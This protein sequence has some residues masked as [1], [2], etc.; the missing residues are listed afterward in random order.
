MLE[1]VSGYIMLC[2]QGCAEQV[3]DAVVGIRAKAERILSGAQD[4]S[5]PDI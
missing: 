3:T 1:L 5:S 4:V 2:F